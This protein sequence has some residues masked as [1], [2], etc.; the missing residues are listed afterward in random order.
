DVRLSL[1]YRGGSFQQKRSNRE[2][3]RALE[4]RIFVVFSWGII[5]LR[6]RGVDEIA[7]GVGV[8]KG[9]VGAQGLNLRYGRVVGAQ[10]PQ[11]HVIEQRAILC[12][13]DCSLNGRRKRLLGG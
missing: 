2:A 6:A 3:S 11:P 8:R 9:I 13:I 7:I 12:R 10:V 4:R 5:K 1:G